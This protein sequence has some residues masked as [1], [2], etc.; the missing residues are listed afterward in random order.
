[1]IESHSSSFEHKWIVLT[2]LSKICENPQ[3]IVDIYVNY[4]CH[5]TSANVFEILVAQLSK[6]AVFIFNSI[7]P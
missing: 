4:D 3:N 7:L 5:L 6:I 1:M 2:S